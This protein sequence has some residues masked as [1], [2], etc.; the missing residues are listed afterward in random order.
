MKI[1]KYIS[2]EWYEYLLCYFAG[3]EYGY[4]SVES[5]VNDMWNYYELIPNDLLAVK[6]QLDDLLSSD[7][8]DKE[9]RKYWPTNIAHIASSDMRWWYEFLRESMKKFLAEH[10]DFLPPEYRDK[11]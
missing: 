3:F 9:L 6:K 4:D 5:A 2:K 7:Y 10:P 1:P 11:F 8:S